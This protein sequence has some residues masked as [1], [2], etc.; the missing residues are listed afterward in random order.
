MV[1]YKKHAALGT[2][3]DYGLFHRLGFNDITL[4]IIGRPPEDG[5]DNSSCPSLLSLS[6]VRALVALDGDFVGVDSWTVCQAL[7][8]GDSGVAD[9]IVSSCI[10]DACRDAACSSLGTA[11]VMLTSVSRSTDVEPVIKKRKKMNINY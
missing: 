4:V 2:F 6:G 3:L 10:G 5:D 1:A 11:W 9:P 7:V 8:L